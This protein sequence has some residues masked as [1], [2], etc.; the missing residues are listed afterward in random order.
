MDQFKEILC[1]YPGAFHLQGTPLG[2]IKGFYHNTDTGDSPP[3][4]QFPYRKSPS[5]LCAIKNE[6]Q[7]CYL[8][9]LFS[10]IILLMGLPAF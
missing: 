9:T 5:E 4:Y 7:L 8:G 2:T 6:L 3:V 1:K 10:Q